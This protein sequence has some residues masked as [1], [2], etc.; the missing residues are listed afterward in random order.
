MKRKE[1]TLALLLRS[2]PDPPTLFNQQNKCFSKREEPETMLST[3]FI[4]YSEDR[5]GKTHQHKRT[6]KPWKT[7]TAMKEKNKQPGN[8]EKTHHM[9]SA[10]T[11]SVTS[12][13]FKL[14]RPESSDMMNPE[15]EKR[16]ET[17]VSTWLFLSFFL[18]HPSP[19]PPCYL[20]TT[21]TQRRED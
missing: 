12:E 21:Q 13:R 9:Y 20:P 14:M 2:T 11:F 1:T 3:Q 8:G 18:P 17:Q 16:K 6:L 4:D 5:R 15:K 10:I 7:K 19:K